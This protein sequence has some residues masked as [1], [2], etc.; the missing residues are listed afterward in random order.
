MN[1]VE[2]GQE[3]V[4]EVF[5]N[6]WLQAEFYPGCYPLALLVDCGNN[7]SNEQRGNS[8]RKQF[9]SSSRLPKSLGCMC[10]PLSLDQSGLPREMGHS[11]H[12]GWSQPLQLSLIREGKFTYSQGNQGTETV[13]G[14]KDAS[15]E[16]AGWK[17]SHALFPGDMPLILPH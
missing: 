8:I 1:W 9:P 2:E 6:T 11:T 13:E 5:L 4:R 7:Y 12:C 16:K 14:R 17:K 15:R 3:R 10:P